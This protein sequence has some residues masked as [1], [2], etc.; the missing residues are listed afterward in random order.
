M[1]SY[2]NTESQRIR[3]L[4]RN[5]Q[6]EQINNKPPKSSRELFKLLREITSS[7]TDLPIEDMSDNNISHFE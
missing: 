3:T 2:P 1:E 5:A 7:T 6:K 4:I